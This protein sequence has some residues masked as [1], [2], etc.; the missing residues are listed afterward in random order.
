[1]NLQSFEVCRYHSH[2]MATHKNIPIEMLEEVREHFKSK[3]IRIRVRY[4]GPRNDLLD[5]RRKETKQLTCLKQFA[6]RFSVYR[7]R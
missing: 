7:M 5:T 6:N 2:E 3:G 1:M 4:R